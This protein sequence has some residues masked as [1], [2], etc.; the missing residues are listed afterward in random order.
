MRVHASNRQKK[1]LRFFGVPFSPNLSAGAAGWEIEQL[2]CD[3]SR[4]E[5]WR[6]YL[7]LTKDFDSDTDQVKAHSAAALEAVV[8]PEDWSGSEAIQQFKQELVADMLRDQSPFDRPQ[9]Q[10]VFVGK[11]FVFTGKFVFGSRKKCQEAVVWRKGIAPDLKSVT[12]FVDYLVVGVEGSAAWKRGA[13]GNKI[14]AAV[15]SRREHG[16]PAII[17][18]QHWAAAL[19]QACT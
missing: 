3:E 12:Q 15:L 17:S 11:T 4:R 19:N 16:A 8:V 18:E 2:L 5:R 6:R 10:V 13:Y 14:E 9:P 1:I 7:F